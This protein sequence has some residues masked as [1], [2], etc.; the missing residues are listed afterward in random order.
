LL[1]YFSIALRYEFPGELFEGK[2]WGGHLFAE[3]AQTAHY[4]DFFTLSGYLR[5]ASSTFTIGY[6]FGKKSAQKYKYGGK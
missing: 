5:N 4:T 1:P 2:A 3:F 6:N